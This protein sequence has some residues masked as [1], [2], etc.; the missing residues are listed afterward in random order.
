VSCLCMQEGACAPSSADLAGILGERM[1]GSRSLGS[2]QQ[3][4]KEGVLFPCRGLGG[5]FSLELA[6]FIVNSEPYF[7]LG[8]L[9]LNFRLKWL[10]A[11][12]CT[13]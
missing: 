5:I 6:C 4:G 1:G 9:Q 12:L 13:M 7:C 3:V 11:R 2:G 10:F 8:L